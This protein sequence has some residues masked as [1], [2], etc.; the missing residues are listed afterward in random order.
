MEVLFSYKRSHE[1]DLPY[2][3]DAKGGKRP[4]TIRY[5]IKWLPD[6]LLSDKKRPD[7]FAQGDSV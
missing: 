2:E 3:D 7:L 5:L 6:N 4:P 1:V